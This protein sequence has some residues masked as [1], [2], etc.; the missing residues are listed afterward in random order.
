MS[1]SAGVPRPRWRR[2]SAADPYAHYDGAYVLGALSDA[3]RAAFQGHLPTCPDCRQRVEE[4]AAV[5]ALLAGVPGEAFMTAD[6][7]QPDTLL[8]DLLRAAGR[9]R[10]RRRTLMGVIGSLAAAA[11][12]ALVVL[13]WPSSHSPGPTA[14]A[15][16]PVGRSDVAATAA[17]VSRGWGTE[18]DLSCRY[19]GDRPDS[20]E[21]RLVVRDRQQRA[22][23][24]GSWTFNSDTA[25]TFTGGTAL[26]LDQISEVQVVVGDHPILKLPT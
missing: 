21:Y 25:V 1:T 24:A 6:E 26:P 3:E 22:R 11:V 14:H 17:L 18:I 16:V 20:T 8:P 2:P 4:V 5:P 7:K 10:M 9:E 13:S 23:G 15:M 19:E 12:L